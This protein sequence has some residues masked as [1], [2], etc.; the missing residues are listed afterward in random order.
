[1]R[2]GSPPLTNFS[3]NNG[4]PP[5]LPPRP[6]FGT[7]QQQSQQ[8]LF[9]GQQPAFVPYNASGMY[10]YNFY[11][12]SAPFMN[13]WGAA[14][15]KNNFLLAA[16]AVESVVNAL[17]SV[18]N[19]LN[20][21]HSAVFNTFRAV[22]GVAQQFRAFK[23]YVF[24]FLFVPIFRWCR[25]LWR[26]L[27]SLLRVR[28]RNYA[29]SEAIWTNIHQQQQ[30]GVSFSSP[31]FASLLFWLIALGGPF[32]LFKCVLRLAER[33][34]EANKWTTGQTDHYTAQALFDFCAANANELALT[35]FD[36]IRIAP[37]SA[38]PNIKDWLLASTLDGSKVGLVP[39]NY[40]KLIGKCNDRNAQTI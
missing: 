17:V 11:Q 28:P 38:Q 5:S 8:Q 19:M 24:S 34:T 20:T 21:T 35:A 26:H 32:L 13:P 25:F 3:S 40:I 2:S 1:M 31:N 33:E 16:E 4:N 18:A 23:I 27:L 7:V 29:N 22:A 12:Q 14:H 10:N 36:V 37:K 9:V 39:I 15:S 6:N 30:S